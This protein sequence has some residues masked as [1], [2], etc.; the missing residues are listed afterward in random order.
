MYD[1]NNFIF[2]FLIFRFSREKKTI[3]YIFT[4][5]LWLALARSNFTF[6]TSFF[7]FHALIYLVVTSNIYRNVKNF[8]FLS[9]LALIFVFVSVFT[10]FP[11]NNLFSISSSLNSQW[12]YYDCVSNCFWIVLNFIQNVSCI[13]F[14]FCFFFSF[15]SFNCHALNLKKIKISSLSFPSSTMKI[16]IQC[17]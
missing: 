15:I 2:V 6:E 1:I 9:F 17:K 12:I 7:S 3:G 8:S 13:N 16:A 4:F 5:Y 14:F 10:F 11:F